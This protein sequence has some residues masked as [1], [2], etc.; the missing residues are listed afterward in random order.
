MSQLSFFSAEST[1]PSVVDVGGLLAGTGQAVTAEAGARISVVVDDMWRAEAVAEMIDEAG[2][3]VEVARS[4]EGRP[5]VRTGSAVELRPVVALWTRG[6][7]KAVPAGW[8]PGSRQLRMWTIACGRSE[9]D[10]TRFVLGLDPH[11]PETHGPLARCLMHAG[12]APT[13]I[14]TRGAGPGLRISGRRRL[15]RLAE[16]VGE[17]PR[18]AVSGVSWPC[19]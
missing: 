6:A 14:G 12:I 2:V 11:A 3:V 13:L 9:A 5:L 8:V 1:P 18:H 15:A 19:V 10:G 4:E 16:S 7:V 17:P